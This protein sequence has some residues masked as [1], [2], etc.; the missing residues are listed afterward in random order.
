PATHA[1]EPHADMLKALRVRIICLA[2]GQNTLPTRSFV[3]T[4]TGNA[5]V[6]ARLSKHHQARTI[7]ST[8]PIRLQG[9][10]TLGVNRCSTGSH[11]LTTDGLSS[12][13]AQGQAEEPQPS[14]PASRH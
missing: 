12:M 11:G 9:R 4:A 3:P 1:A 6:M 10:F 14:K 8:T 2:H 5:P 7:S 13:V